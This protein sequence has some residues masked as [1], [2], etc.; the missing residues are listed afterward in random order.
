M[1]YTKIGGDRVSVIGLGA[2][3]FG[4]REWGWTE[5]ALDTAVGI[6]HRALELGI[7]L[8]DTAELYG[9]GRSEEILGAALQG[10]REQVFLATKVFPLLPLS[11]RVRRSAEASLERLKMDRLD[12]YQL[13]FDN[14]LFPLWLQMGGLR[15]LQK[16]GLTRHAGVSNFGLERWRKA[17]KILGSPIASNQVEYHLLKRGAEKMFDWA[18]ANDRAIIA[19]SPLAQGL[20]S[21]RHSA[22]PS[23]ARRA[24]P[25][26]RQKNIAKAKPVLEALAA[27]AK[28]HGATLAQTALAWV[29]QGP[30]VVA[31][32]GAKSVRQLEENAAAADLKLSKD[33]LAL[34]DLVSSD[35]LSGRRA[36]RK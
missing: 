8:I 5:A 29:I 15:E 23:D 31:I 22:A 9:F 30:N 1:R 13:H 28:R 18:R 25:L 17:E 7:N 35:S 36:A 6:V 24:N 11:S 19:Y 4:A 16:A 21:G 10:R 27:V 12:L 2:W 26:F 3:Q 14:R 32:P 34:L 20:L 33:D